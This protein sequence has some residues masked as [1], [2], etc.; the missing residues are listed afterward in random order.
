[1][2]GFLFF[3]PQ[4][5]YPASPLNGRP[6]SRLIV[7]TAQRRTLWRSLSAAYVYAFESRL[8][9]RELG[10]FD[11]QAVVCLVHHGP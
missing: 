10:V 6:G 4:T 3:S 8:F 1:M 2:G 9:L 7:K 5:V 11:E